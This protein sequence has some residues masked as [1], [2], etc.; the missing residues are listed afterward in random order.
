MRILIE[1]RL[2]QNGSDLG[3]MP[4]CNQALF[5]SDAASCDPA[6]GKSCPTHL[7]IPNMYTVS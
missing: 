4:P 7:Y 1:C 6:S 2:T 3:T 5:M